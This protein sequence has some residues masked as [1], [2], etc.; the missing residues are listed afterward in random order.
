MNEITMEQAELLKSKKVAELRAIAAAFGI[1]DAE[2][3]KKAELLRLL[4]PEEPRPA[5]CKET[6]RVK[7]VPSRRPAAPACDEPAPDNSVLSEAPDFLLADAACKKGSLSFVRAENVEDSLP[8]APAFFDEESPQ[9][10]LAA[11]EAPRFYADGISS[12]RTAGRRLYASD[13]PAEDR[14][15]RAYVPTEDRPEVEGILE[16][17]E[18]GYGF[19]RF[20]HYRSSERDVY[21]SQIQIRRFNLKTGDKIRGIIRKP[22]AD[23]KFGA[24]LF[25]REI[26]GDEP[27]VAMRRPAFD[28]LTPVYATEPITLDGSD[29]LRLLGY[30]APLA[31]GQRALIIGEPHSGKTALLR[32]L[33]ACL[34][35]EHP[36]L[37]VIVLLVGDRP[38]EVTAIRRA[39]D[40]DVVASTFDEP[41]QQQV[42]LAE[43]ALERA[44]RLVEHKRDVVVL[45]DS[46]TRLVRAYNILTPASGKLLGGALDPSCLYRPK[47]YFG[48]ACKMEEGGSLTLIATLN[49]ETGSRL[50]DTIAHEFRET[51]NCI[52]ALRCDPNVLRF[53]P[54]PNLTKTANRHPELVM[55]EEQAAAVRTLR[56]AAAESNGSESCSQLA[57]LL[58]RCAT[59]AELTEEINRHGLR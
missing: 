15:T 16:V 27:G 40:C 36:E 19:L 59:D 22:D 5:K 17:T 8:A 48:S 43:M 30:C 38:E 53:F 6:V 1:A 20:D 10:S 37:T 35:N 42:K 7:A 50:D 56:A 39:L 12:P 55:S 13:A 29:P 41:P 11:E 24:I 25:I 3:M 32:Q 44:R 28:S 4:V 2:S 9:D 45:L 14:S 31:K 57:A 21:V 52:Y 54:V 49:T 23:E 58:Q 18:Q 47:N 46:M 33:A 34:Q 26:N 51:S